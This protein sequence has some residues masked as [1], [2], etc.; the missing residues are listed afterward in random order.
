MLLLDV[1]ISHGA[2]LY[3]LPGGNPESVSGVQ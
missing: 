1:V 3:N 2:L